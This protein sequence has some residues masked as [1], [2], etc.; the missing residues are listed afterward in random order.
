MDSR[1]QFVA[2]TVA[3]KGIDRTSDF[4]YEG[5][6]SAMVYVHVI[7]QPDLLSGK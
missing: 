2:I 5:N 4:H 1:H 7:C 6:C 3:E